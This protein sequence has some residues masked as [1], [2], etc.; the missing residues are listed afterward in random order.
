MYSIAIRPAFSDAPRPVRY[1]QAKSFH[2]AA[3]LLMGEGAFIIASLN[4]P[5][6]ADRLSALRDQVW[7]WQDAQEAGFRSEREQS[8]HFFFDGTYG[9]SITILEV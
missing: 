2:D 5:D 8:N 6:T 3:C 9:P 1:R 7:E 4:R